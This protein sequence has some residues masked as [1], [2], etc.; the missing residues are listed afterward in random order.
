MVLS[1]F[2]LDNEQD[3]GSQNARIEKKKKE[4]KTKR[5]Y[6]KESPWN[7]YVSWFVSLANDAIL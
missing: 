2:L 6:L 3:T 1:L 7:P 4:R 5:F